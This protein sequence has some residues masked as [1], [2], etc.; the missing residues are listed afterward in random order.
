VL[1]LVRALRPRQWVKNLFVAAPI[2]FAQRLTDHDLLLREAIAVLAFCLLSGAVYLFNDVRDVEA[3]RLHP[4]KR[5]RPIASGKLSERTALIASATLAIGSLVGCFLLAPMLAAFAGAYLA[6]NVAYT[7]R[8]KNIAFVDVALI[9][10]GFIL[11]VLGGAAAI[12]VPASHWLLICTGLL[13]ML[14]GFGK[15]AHELAW[16][17][18]EGMRATRGSLGGYR[19]APLRVAMLVLAIVT[20]ALYVAYTL[21]PHTVG[22][23]HTTRLVYSAPFVAAGMARFLVLALWKPKD[24]SPTDAMLRDP[25]FLLALVGAGATMLYAIYG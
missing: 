8:L 12:A 2:V 21:D 25:V 19:L 20:L 18:R 17:E 9:A 7:L 23:F 4:T 16:S 6:Q 3:D 5:N 1:A 24:E 11:R 13:A 22:M 10:S 15:R 14:L